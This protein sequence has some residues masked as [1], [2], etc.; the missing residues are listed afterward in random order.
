MVDLQVAFLI[1]LP[2]MIF[3][4][5]LG[6][7]VG[8]AYPIVLVLSGLVL[9]FIPGLPTVRLD[10]NLVL[11]LFLP[12]LLYWE[13]VT[14]PTD[15]MLANSAQI[16]M[17]TIGLVFATTVAVA[18]AAH[19]IVPS[20]SWSVAFVLGAIVAPTDELAAA[21]VLERFHLPRHVIAIVEG[22]SLSN[23]ALSLILYFAAVS[24]VLTGFFNPAFAALSFV[25][26]TIAAF[27]IGLVAAR[28]AIEGWRRITD[29]QLQG[30]ISLLTPFL[31]YIP[32]VRL[33]ISGVISVITAGVYVSRFTPRLLTSETRLQG[34][35]FWESFVFLANA[36]LFLLVGLQ[37]HGIAAAV[38]REYS[39]PL[40][41]L[42]T[43]VINVVVVG[44]R[45]AWILGAEYLPYVGGASEHPEPNWK[46]ALVVAWSGLRGAVSLAAA[47]AIPVSLANGMPFPRRELIIF[48][49]F[50]V[51]LVTLVGG[52]IT[53]PAVLRSLKIEDDGKEEAEELER[54]FIGTANAA[55]TKM[56]VLE[57]EGRIDAEH[58]RALRRRYEG[59][60]DLPRRW[61]DDKLLEEDERRASVEH[62]LIQ[63]QRDAL[64]AMHDRGEIDNV[65]LRRVQRHLDLAE[66]RARHR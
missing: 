45:F 43:L 17:L 22:E 52:G 65:V 55:L 25:L 44:V 59:S 20:L 48:L 26:G 58:A 34:I 46:H 51:I 19:A 23:D 16:G 60:R 3:L 12:P 30:V 63:A 39:W 4:V 32:A 10:P 18:A 21:P 36:A 56:D 9:G 13:S 6:R 1:A 42:Y 49:T 57:R 50:S 54:A 38:S 2:V 64:I 40:V 28:L 35:G 53:L 47:L 11:L 27:V 15:V 5:A 62:E 41:L 24:A 8:I 31:A 61:R 37:L 33:G 66:Q 7:R 29:P 14:A